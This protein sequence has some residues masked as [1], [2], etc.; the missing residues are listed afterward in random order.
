M[1][2]IPPYDDDD[3]DDV[4]LCPI[5]CTKLRIPSYTV[6]EY[7]S[8]NRAI[9]SLGLVIEYM[10]LVGVA[11]EE[12]RDMEGVEEGSTWSVSKPMGRHW[13]CCRDRT[14]W[15]VH[16]VILFRAKSRGS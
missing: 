6:S 5:V 10:H 14:T 11:W 16:C 12:D 4:L 1:E 8:S 13:N 7:C 15:V 2:S 9:R 3:D